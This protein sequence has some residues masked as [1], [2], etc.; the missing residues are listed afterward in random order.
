ML[1]NAVVGGALM[2]ALPAIAA[3]QNPSPVKVGGV[4]YAQ[5]QYLLSDEA[6]DA[7]NFDVARAYLNVTG[8]FGHGVSG[9]VT[10]DI[11]RPGDGSL[12]YRL[13]YAYAAYTPEN[14]ALT[15]KLG[16]IHT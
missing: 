13:K 5:Y 7:N 4:V 9:R 3:A 11:Y 12:T 8:A 2:I 16:Q 15:F 10:A 14:S 1:R 6:G